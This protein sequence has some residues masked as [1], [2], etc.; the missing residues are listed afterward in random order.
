MDF[1]DKFLFFSAAALQ[2]FQRV[3]DT[4]YSVDKT[5]FHRLVSVEDRA[6][7][8]HEDVG[9]VHH[10]SEIVLVHSRMLDDETDNS[11]L[12]RKSF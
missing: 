11:V 6:D 4:A 5:T 12:P 9:A 10:L 7:V 3:A 2:I 1:P 8:V